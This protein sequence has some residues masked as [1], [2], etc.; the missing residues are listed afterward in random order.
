MLGLT[1]AG[2]IW[3]NRDTKCRH[4]KIAINQ[5]IALAAIVVVVVVVVMVCAL[6][7]IIAV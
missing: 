1:L 3:R 2:G 4:D 6:A 7:I 5:L